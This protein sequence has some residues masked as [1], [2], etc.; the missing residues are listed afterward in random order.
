MK[1]KDWVEFE[2]IV[3]MV[4]E[5]LSPDAEVVHNVR[6]PVIN[7][8]SN[9][10]RQCDVVIYSGSGA[11]RTLTI[12]E[13]QLRKSKVDINTFNGW[14][15]K[16]RS[17]GAQHLICVSRHDFPISIKEEAIKHGDSVRLVVL[18]ETIPT[19]CPINMHF[20]NRNFEVTDITEIQ[21]S[22]PRNDVENHVMNSITVNDKLWS[23]NQTTLLS[24][25][26]LCKD[27]V[28][29]LPGDSSGCDS[30]KFLASSESPLYFHFNGRIHKVDFSCEFTW[31]LTI[32]KIKP[33]MLSYEQTDSGVLAWF[34]E[35]CYMSN[36]Q[37]ATVQ[38]TLI[39]E[40][41]TYRVG[42]ISSDIP[43]HMKLDMGV[44]RPMSN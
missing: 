31:E 24:I 13:V 1:K 6:L 9:L 30:L 27:K 43:E 10:R 2:K 12:V 33:L 11:R 4:E 40:G 21:V 19:N 20:E 23:L 16:F 14:I 34:I 37:L 3:S 15:R 25:Y 42:H 39:N 41:E 7:S 17:V 44:I 8:P 5:G 26:H 35:Y 36:E 32:E 38:I 29:K 18:K 28:G 22:L